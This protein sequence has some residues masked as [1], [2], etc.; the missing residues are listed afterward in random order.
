MLPSLSYEGHINLL[1]VEI[2][3]VNLFM[4]LNRLSR[5]INFFQCSNIIKYNILK[6]KLTV[7]QM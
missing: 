4:I 1:F 7:K 2:K 6:L 5:F 3:N